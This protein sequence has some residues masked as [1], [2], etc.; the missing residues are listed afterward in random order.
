MPQGMPYPK[1][2]ASMKGAKS[3]SE[4][5]GVG[6]ATGKPMPP[7]KSKKGMPMKGKKTMSKGSSC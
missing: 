3:M 2:N 6:K 1:G 5:M 7:M 4:M